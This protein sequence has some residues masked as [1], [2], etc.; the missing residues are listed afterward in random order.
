MKP[1]PE[2]LRLIILPTFVMTVLM[3]VYKLIA[4]LF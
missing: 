2:K 4:S 1:L 3:C